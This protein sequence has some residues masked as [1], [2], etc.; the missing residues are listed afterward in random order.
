MLTRIEIDGFKTFEEF[1]VDL[2]PMQV[3]LGPNA[4]GKSNL[5]D[6]IRL[7]SNLAQSDLRSS[8]RG[9]RGEPVELFRIGAGSRSS[10]MAFAVELLLAP[11]VRDSWG[12]TVKISHSRV[13]Y[14]IEIELRQ[15]SLGLERL[16]VVKEAATPIQPERDLWLQRRISLQF[17]Q[18][19]LKYGHSEPW[20][21]TVET[22]GQHHFQIMPDASGVG[23]TQRATNAQQSVLSSITTAEYPH[24]YAI[25]EE[26]RSWRFLQL[27]P[28]KLRRPS[29]TTAAF[30]LEPDGANLATVLA[31]IQTE[32]ATESQPKGAIAD[33]AAALTSLISGVVD[34][35]ISLDRKNKEYQIEIGYR[36]SIP[37]S[38]RVVSD[39][40][41]RV[42]ALL[43]LLYDPKHSGL[44]CFEEPENGVHPFRLKTLIELLRSGVT[45][46]TSEEVD[47]TEPLFQM[48]LNS[49]SPIVL[50][51]LEEPEALFADIVSVVKPEASTVSRKTRIRPVATFKRESKA[52]S[53]LE[54]VSPFEVERYLHSVDRES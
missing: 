1:G 25:R 23:R 50:A 32:T 40:T 44:V 18:A 51:G 33:I 20:L 39:G 4:S 48:L 35:D 24:L 19:F 6:A 15:V 3:I 21:T 38:S 54:Y 41:L 12:E 29:P 47:E 36:D 37:F 52:E 46:I 5:F 28:Y 22:N 7:L 9:L 26:M 14:E 11:C 49:H 8:V 53:E 27:D 17:Q 13:R 34:L 31:K 42:L 16:V 45:D 30:E 43:V 10:R 2:G